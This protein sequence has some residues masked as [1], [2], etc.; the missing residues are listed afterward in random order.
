VSRPFVLGDLVAIFG[1]LGNITLE[2]F[3]TRF[4]P[5]RDRL[6]YRKLKGERLT[7]SE[8][9]TLTSMNEWLDAQLPRGERLPKDIRDLVDEILRRPEP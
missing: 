4:K 9:N 7:G 8:E 2:E 3:A 5:L 1:D 6:T